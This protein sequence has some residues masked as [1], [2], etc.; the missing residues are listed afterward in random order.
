MYKAIRE[1]VARKLYF[2]FEEYGDETIAEASWRMMPQGLKDKWLIKA[3]S[4]LS[5]RL[6]DKG[7]PDPDGDWEIVARNRKT[8]QLESLRR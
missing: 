6:N 8:G 7:E 5:I 3:E 4:I 1:R 2:D